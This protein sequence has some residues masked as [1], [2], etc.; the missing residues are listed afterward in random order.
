MKSN[1][2]MIFKVV[3]GVAF[4]LAIGYGA[5]LI[6]RPAPKIPSAESTV[7]QRVEFMASSD[8]NRLPEDVRRKYLAEN[9]QRWGSGERPVLTEPQRQQIQEN[10]RGLREKMEKERLLAYFAKTP[11]ERRAF[12]KEQQKR[13]EEMRK[14]MAQNRPTSQNDSTVS[15]SSTASNS[16]PNTGQQAQ[17][18]RNSDPQQR[19][20]RRLDN[21]SPET[22]ALRSAMFKDMR[23]NR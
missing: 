4:A 20:K 14:Q 13:M 1:K 5:F 17:S 10:T 22:R 6:F 12:S 7:Q 23:R 3:G 9:R 21:S 11:E 2:K 8:F 18:R 16:S 19:V 15:N